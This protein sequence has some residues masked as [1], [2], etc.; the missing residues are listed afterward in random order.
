VWLQSPDLNSRRSQAGTQESA[1]QGQRGQ[2]GCIVDSS[3]DQGL[4]QPKLYQNAPALSNVSQ[5]NGLQGNGAL[6]KFSVAAILLAEDSGNFDGGT[7]E[8]KCLSSN[9]LITFELGK[10]GLMCGK[11]GI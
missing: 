6:T 10:E 11:M 8:I 7:Y 2:S 9:S 5:E 1:E 4:Q 3:R